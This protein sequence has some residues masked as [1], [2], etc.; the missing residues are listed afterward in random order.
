MAMDTV[1]ASAKQQVENKPVMISGA[2]AV[3]RCLVE[4]KIEVIYGYPGGAIMP[5]YDALFHF[6]DKI[7]HVLVRHEQ[8]ATHAAE[9]WARIRNKA[10]VCFATSGPGAT[11]LVTGIADAI[12]DACPMVCITGQVPRHL[13]GTDAFQ[14]T[15]V[16]GITMPVTKWNYQV[17][18]AAEIP[19][20][21]AKAFHIA[22]TGKPGPVLI[23]ITK[24]AQFEMMEWKG[25]QPCEEVRGYHHLPVAKVEDL[26]AAAELINA[27]KKPLLFAGHGVLISGAEE[28]LKAVAEKAGLPV[29]TT[30]QGLGCFSPDHPLYVG[31]PGMH[32][33][34]GPNLLSAQCDVLIAVGMRF[35]DRVTGDVTRFAK[36]AKVIHIEIDPSEIDKV[37]K[38]HVAINAD[39]K[40]ALEALLPLLGTNSHEEWL[41]K[42]RECD[43]EEYEKVIKPEAYPESGQIKMGELMRMIDDKT[44]GEAIIV[45]DVGQHQMMAMRYYHYR[46]PNSWVASGGLGTMGFA[47]PA[48]LGAQMA[49]PDRTVVAIV[50]DGCFQMTLQELGT[51]WQNK[52][53]VKIVIFNNNFLGMVR[54]WQQLFFDNRYS[55]VELVNPDFVA[56]TKGFGI[57]AE[58]VEER[59]GLDA[60]L[61]RMFAHEGPY[62]LEVMVEKEANVFP[63]VPSGAAASDI[64]LERPKS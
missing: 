47:I 60:A 2:E 14:E 61:N 62:L 8:G 49:A 30:L 24:N 18:R 35:D 42:F 10:T 17:T 16:V 33:N 15:D 46:K 20:A 57:P 64:I 48:A 51:I 21:I 40:A 58:K 32:G 3:I 54:Q 5:I 38:T 59:E 9:G 26:Q 11:N 1:T 19:A 56:I 36:Q 13:L 41:E 6:T 23:D 34:Y 63:M 39:A 55:Q 27:S 43:K 31:V 37:V 29:T 50:G 12:M 53:P 45:P 7:N 52:L 25:Y 4:E 22:N 28:A 44:N